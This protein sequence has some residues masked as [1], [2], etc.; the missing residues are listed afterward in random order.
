MAKRNDI[1]SQQKSLL[2]PQSDFHGDSRRI[3]NSE[4]GESEHSRIDLNCGKPL[5][6]FHQIGLP[7]CS[8][9]RRSGF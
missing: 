7:E 6:S 8:D 1:F 3:R 4:V 2:R 9:S 5:P